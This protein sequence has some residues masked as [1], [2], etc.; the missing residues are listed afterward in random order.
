MLDLTTIDDR[1]DEIQ[2]ALPRMLED[3]PDQVDFLNAFAGETEVLEEQAGR[4]AEHV[5]ARISDLLRSAG[6][7]ADGTH[8]RD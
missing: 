6:V 5:Y 8:A 3:Y 1:L 7:L 2:A 4:H